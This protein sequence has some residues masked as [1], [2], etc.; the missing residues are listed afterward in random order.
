MA[1]KSCLAHLAPVRCNTHVKYWCIQNPTRTITMRSVE[2]GK[3]HH[4]LI[5]IQPMTPRKSITFLFLVLKQQSIKVWNLLA[6]A[7]CSQR[8]KLML[9]TPRPCCSWNVNMA[10]DVDFISLSRNGQYIGFC[11]ALPK[12]E[13]KYLIGA[14]KLTSFIWELWEHTSATLHAENDTENFKESESDP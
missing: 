5:D 12:T 1:E 7:P 13:S 6:S 8:G 9:S 11:H 3:V 14:S 4:L 10:S 2:F